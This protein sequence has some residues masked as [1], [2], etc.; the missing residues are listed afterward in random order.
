MLSLLSMAGIPPAAGFIG[1]F[2]LFSEAIREGY[3]WM[4]FLGV[5]LS[6]V[7]IYY[8]LGV[9]RVMLVDEPVEISK[10]KIPVALKWVMGIS[11]GMTLV[12]G[13]YPGPITE[14]TFKIA[15]SFLKLN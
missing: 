9:I 10:V 14:W 4:A 11:M 2:Y 1:K 5:A 3:L 8:Y 7:S 12:M 13:I 15:S 6:V